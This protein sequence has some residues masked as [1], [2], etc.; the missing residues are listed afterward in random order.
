[1]RVSRLI[2]SLAV[3]FLLAVSALSVEAAP[4]RFNFTFA[5]GGAT[6]VGFIVLETTL[7]PNPGGGFIAL[8]DPS[9]VD[10]QVTVSGAAG[11]NGTFG[12]AS[13][14]AVVFDTGPGALNLRA[15]LV[16]QPSGGGSWGTTAGDFNLFGVAP[17]PNGVG[18]FNLESNG[19]AGTTMALVSMAA[20]ASPSQVPTMS[21]WMLLLMVLAVASLGVH[22]LRRFRA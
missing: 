6:A 19:G 21:E 12:I 7:I 8:P 20:A 16:G 14:T 15:E 13:F 1:M 18:P 4:M 17:T 3:F 9:V 11:G 2:K 5:T 22:Q 10:L